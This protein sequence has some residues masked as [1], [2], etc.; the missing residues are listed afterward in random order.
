MNEFIFYFASLSNS[1]GVLLLDCQERARQWLSKTSACSEAGN[2]EKPNIGNIQERNIKVLGLRIEKRHIAVRTRADRRRLTNDVTQ[3]AL[4]P[5]E[6]STHRRPIVICRSS[7]VLEQVA[8]RDVLRVR[9][10]HCNIGCKEMPNLSGG[11]TGSRRSIR[12][13][14]SNNVRAT[15]YS[16]D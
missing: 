12:V 6:I 1:R 9:I 13:Y 8:A 7:G 14:N 5:F 3:Y 15:L 11:G 10:R 4:L 2:V 16:L